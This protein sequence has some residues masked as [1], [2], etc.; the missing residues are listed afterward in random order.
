MQLPTQRLR[1]IKKSPSF[2]SVTT[3]T[4]RERES[5]CDEAQRSYLYCDDQAIC[6][7][8]GVAQG[9]HTNNVSLSLCV[10]VRDL[11]TRGF[12]FFFSPGRRYNRLID[13]SESIAAHYGSM[14]LYFHFHFSSLY[15]GW[16]W[17]YHPIHKLYYTR[18][19]LPN[20]ILEHY[21]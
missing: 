16:K 9:R 1:R 18:V 8:I 19:T 5:V 14:F 11:F 4:L 21:C 3:I 15:P 10:C 17:R 6:L 2:W 13:V 12:F 7:M 20:I